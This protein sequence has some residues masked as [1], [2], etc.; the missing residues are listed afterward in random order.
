MYKSWLPT[1]GEGTGAGLPEEFLATRTAEG[2]QQTPLT[3]PQGEG[4]GGGRISTPEA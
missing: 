1:L 3:V 4:V 2:W